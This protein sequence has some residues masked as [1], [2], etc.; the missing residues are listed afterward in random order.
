MYDIGVNS[1]GY[2]TLLE[3]TLTFDG[4]SVKFEV[5][6]LFACCWLLLLN[7]DEFWLFLSYDDITRE[8]D[9]VDS[10]YDEY[11]EK[12]DYITLSKYMLNNSN[13]SLGL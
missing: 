7:N 12:T 3:F 5:L 9:E 4:G 6:C 10:L 2:W 8:I 11:T 13:A 1:N